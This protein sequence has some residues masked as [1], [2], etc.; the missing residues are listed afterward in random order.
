MRLPRGTLYPGL[1]LSTKAHAKI[2][3][4]DSSAALGMEGVV[5]YVGAEDLPPDCNLIGPIMPDEE[6][7]ARD[8]VR[9]WECC[10]ECC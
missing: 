2:L 4:V 1:V 9:G 7:F 5:R 6:I 10:L 8:E 3:S